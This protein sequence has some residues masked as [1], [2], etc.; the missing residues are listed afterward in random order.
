MPL[1]DDQ[2]SAL[3]MLARSA[4]GYSLSTM[5]ARGFAYDMLQGLVRAGF[6]V[7]RRETGHKHDK[8]C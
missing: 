7:A 3:R 4:H 8:S 5:V 2:R 6:A 1:T